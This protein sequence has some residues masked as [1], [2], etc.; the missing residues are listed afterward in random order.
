VPRK[1]VAGSL[2]LVCEKRLKTRISKSIAARNSKEICQALGIYSIADQGM[3]VLKAE[4][5]ILTRNAI[6]KSGK[7]VN[8]LVE[9]SGVSRS[10]VSAIRNGALAGISLDLM[11]RV[12][13]ATGVRLKFKVAA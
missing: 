4:L 13:L 10:K 3:V 9:I 11:L 12:L 1:K 2:A 5:S 8:E 7:S 6:L